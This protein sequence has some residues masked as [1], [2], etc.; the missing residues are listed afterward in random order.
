MLYE[1]IT[2]GLLVLR[3]GIDTL[4]FAPPLNITKEE[5]KL[6]LEIIEKAL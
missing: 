1:V 2:N 6:G 4:R 5:I 3:T